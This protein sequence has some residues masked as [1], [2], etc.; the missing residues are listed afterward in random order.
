MG[1]P[2]VIEIV[3]S[4][5]SADFARLADDIA[6]A[7]AAGCRI[8]HLDVM[9]GHFVP[10]L[11]IGPVVAAAVRQATRSYLA[12]HLMVEKPE[13]FLKPFADA[14]V[15]EIV[16]HEE[17][18]GDWVAVL[19]EI[20]R[21]GL[22]AGVSIR[23]KTPVARL[24]RGL[25]VADT[26]LIMSV[27]PGFGGQEYI[28]GSERKVEEACALARSAGKEIVIEIDGGITPR[29]APLAAR[30]GATRLIAG[31]AVFRGDIAENV[32]KLRAAV[33]RIATNRNESDQ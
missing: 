10:N 23:P 8:F 3:P 13:M 2:A 31:S 24:Q 9:D 11:T 4:L 5:L 25:A 29:T 18:A 1:S 26:I 14:G 32:R 19:E 33:R 21:L 17:I 28:P 22:K 15:E 30:A 20:R 7:E 12:A 16:I 27:E 6:R